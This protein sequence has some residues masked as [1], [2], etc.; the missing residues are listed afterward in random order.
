MCLCARC[1][2]S[3]VSAK[4]T[5][6]KLYVFNDYLV[7]TIRKTLKPQFLVTAVLHNFL[8][9]PKLVVWS[10]QCNATHSI[11]HTCYSNVEHSGNRVII[12]FK[13]YLCG[14]NEAIRSNRFSLVPAACMG[15]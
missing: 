10:L 6:C 1:K 14:L 11:S 8:Q 13:P 2:S 12:L 15:Y 5:L 7:W 9:K 4:I 3:N